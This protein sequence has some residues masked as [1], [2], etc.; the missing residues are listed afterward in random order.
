[1]TYIALSSVASD[2]G[3]TTA[4]VRRW[5][6]QSIRP[7]RAVKLGGVTV[8]T[9]EWLDEFRREINQGGLVAAP[10]SRGERARDEFLRKYKAG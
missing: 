1:M 4:S 8:T 10:A 2:L 7:L 3:I 9:Q 5:T 6:R